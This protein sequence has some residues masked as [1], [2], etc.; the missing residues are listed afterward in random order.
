[1]VES[2]KY[3]QKIETGDHLVL[4]YGNEK[5]GETVASF[6]AESLKRNERCMYVNGDTDTDEMLACLSKIIDVDKVIE[7]NQLFILDKSEAYSKN[8]VFVPDKMIDLLKSES[9][10]ATSDGYSGL[11]VTGEL[12]WVLDYEDG[13]EKIIEYE[14]KLNDRV[15]SNHPVTALCRYNLDKFTP[16]MIKSII[17][18]HPFII[19]DGMINE[20]PYYV[21]PEGYRDNKVEEYE[22]MSWLK[23]INSFTKTKSKFISDIEKRDREYQ[24]LFNRIQD[25]ICVSQV[26]ESMKEVIITKANKAA[27]KLSGFTTEELIGKNISSLDPTPG[28]MDLA[29][30]VPIGFE[31]TFETELLKS[32]GSVVAVEI[33]TKLYEENSKRFILTVARDISLRKKYMEDILTTVTN[34]LEIH[35]KYTKGHSEKVALLA[36]QTAKA[37]GLRPEKVNEAYLTGLVHDIG[38]MLIPDEILNKVKDLDEQEYETIMMH[39]VWAYDAISKNEELG[40]IAKNARHHHERWDGN[41]YPDGLKGDEIPIISQILIVADAYDAMT[42]KRTYRDAMTKERA[43]AELR[44]FKGTQ[45]PPDIVDV[46]IEKVLK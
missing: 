38:K 45:F 28:L 37:M 23:N 10:A 36:R 20:N 32:D 9:R 1:M 18:L 11:S 3:M 2:L 31:T 24:D 46:F 35:D 16:S 30:T 21:E 5:I 25:G 4:L 12:S 42:S 39:P 44:A 22:V 29:S 15:F 13:R 33:N 8:G 26:D 40:G 6:I 41:G 14:W 43:I 19:H 17:E 7:K 34:F 27:E